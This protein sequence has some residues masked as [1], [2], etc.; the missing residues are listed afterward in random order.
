M[1]TYNVADVTERARTL[2]TAHLTSLDAPSQI[3]SVTSLA[4]KSLMIAGGSISQ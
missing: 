3:M 1:K 4:T 2:I